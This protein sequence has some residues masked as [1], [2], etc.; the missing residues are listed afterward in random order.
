MPKSG[1]TLL[2]QA[3]GVDARQD[4]WRELAQKGGFKDA[5]QELSPIGIARAAQ[6]ASVDDLL[7]LAD[8][9]RLSG[10]SSEAVGPLTR[11]AQEHGGDP[12]ASMAAFTLGR[13]QLDSLGRAAGAAQAF[14]RAIAL[15]LPLGLREDAYARV[16]EARAR[17][18][19]R[20]GARAAAAE[21]EARYP[22]GS[23]LAEVRAW[24]E[25]E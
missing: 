21:Y 10:H 20:A 6:T 24:A 23:R 4:R 17:A 11:V 18:G 25:R 16:V 8:V 12:R 3:R 19:D 7:L 14:S 5:Y 15:G 9:A 1:G 22:G 2:D 13:L